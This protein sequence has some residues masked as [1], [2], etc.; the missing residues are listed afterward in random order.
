VTPSFDL[1]AIFQ[2]YLLRTDK[3]LYGVIEINNDE[4]EPIFG[5]AKIAIGQ[6]TE[7]EAELKMPSQSKEE[8][9]IDN[10][11]HQWKSQ[12]CEIAGRIELNYDLLSLFN[13]DISKALAIQVYI[14]VIELNSGQE[15]IIH[16]V[17]PVFTHDVI[18][19]ILPLEFQAGVS[20]EF[21]II[22]KRPDGKPVKME[23]MIVTVQMI[24]GNEQGK[25]QDQKSVEIKDFYTR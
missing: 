17:I 5:R 13:V 1:K 15:R 18:Y 25:Q 23:N 12:E 3:T 6:I 14:Q 7:Q 21:E 24:I 9:S 19:D 22:A 10:E 20:N 8:K 4:N 2:R 16:H 11:W